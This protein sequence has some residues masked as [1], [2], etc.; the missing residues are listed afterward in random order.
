MLMEVNSK[1]LVIVDFV[2]LGQLNKLQMPHRH[3]SCILI[4]LAGLLLM[5]WRGAAAY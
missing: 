5:M 4:C 3:V 1:H 2:Y